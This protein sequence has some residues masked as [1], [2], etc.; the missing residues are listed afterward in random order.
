M[1]WFD[2]AFKGRTLLHWKQSLNIA[3]QTLPAWHDAARERV[4]YQ[5]LQGA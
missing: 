4:T 3:D 2:R 1:A 5:T